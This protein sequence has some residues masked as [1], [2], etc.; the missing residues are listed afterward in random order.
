M[1]LS[2]QL[3]MFSLRISKIRNTDDMQFHF[4]TRFIL[5]SALTVTKWLRLKGTLLLY[6]SSLLHSIQTD[7]EAHPVSYPMG[8]GGSFPWGIKQQRRQADHSSPSS[9]EVKEGGAIPPLPHIFIA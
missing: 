9:A 2:L 8:T 6:D 3:Q 4:V 5:V 7:S 1:L